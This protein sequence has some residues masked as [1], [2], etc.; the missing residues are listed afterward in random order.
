[1]KGLLFAPV[2]YREFRCVADKCTHSCCIGWEIDVDRN[3]VERYLSLGGY[4][5]EVVKSL[6]T[7]EDGTRFKLLFDD[8][9]PHLAPDGFCR[10]ITELGEDNLCDICREHP[11]FYN[12]GPKA[13]EVGLGMA[14]EEACRIIL[15]SDGYSDLIALDEIELD[16]GDFCDVTEERNDFYSRLGKRDEPYKKR[17]ESLYSYYGV[18]PSLIKDAEW[19]K[20]LDSLEYLD[21]S[22]RELFKNYSSSLSNGNNTEKQLERAL[23]YFYYRHCS[24]ECSD[25]DYAPSLGFCFFCER[26]FSSLLQNTDVDKITLGRI[27][28]EELEYS[29]DNTETLKDVFRQL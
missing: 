3:S 20:I 19:R 7:D 27:I 15:S 6:E 24:G 22:H 17:L 18:S 4:G 12:R 5:K 28:S 1:M 25:D 13:L 16:E 21:K 2:Y 8:R 29:L 9:C 26:L 11:R 23:A 14:C 10:I